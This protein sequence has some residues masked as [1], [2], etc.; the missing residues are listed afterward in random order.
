MSAHELRLVSHRDH[1]G[2]PGIQPYCP[3]GWIGEPEHVRAGLASGE[4]HDASVAFGAHMRE[5]EK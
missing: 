2:M 4:P 3:C 5:V 1:E